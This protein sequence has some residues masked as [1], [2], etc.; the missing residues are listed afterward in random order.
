VARLAKLNVLPNEERA[1]EFVKTTGVPAESVAC[2]WNC[3]RSEE[4]APSHEEQG[5]GD[6]WLY[7]HGSIN[8]QRLPHSTV[9]ALATLPANVKL[10]IVGYE[11]LGSIG[12]VKGFLAHAARLGVEAGRID[13]LGTLS[14]R[15]SILGYARKSQ[16]GLSFM[17]SGSDD[18]NMQFMVGASNK[19]FDYM[20]CG[21]PCLVTEAPDWVDFYVKAGYAIA[22]DSNSAASL[23][24]AI[25]W[26]LDHPE[27]A[28]QMGENARRRILTDWNYEKQFAPALAVLGDP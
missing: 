2:I 11:T 19:P 1:L 17:P 27:E 15:T 23:A 3:P 4:A 13:Y 24:T 20:A 22:C 12:Y 25:R 9:E 16:V 10:R 7:Y 8:E 28:R 5:D 26:F 18:I 14:P 21:L 6:L